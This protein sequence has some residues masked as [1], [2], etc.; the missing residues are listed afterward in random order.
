[1]LPP[2]LLVTRRLSH[3]VEARAS[4]DYDAR[5]NAD[6]ANWAMDGPEITR[7]ASEVGA[8]GILCAPG[9]RVDSACINALPP[10]V[11][12]IATLSVGFDHID[13]AAARARGIV[14]TNTPGVLS[15]AVA[16]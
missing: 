1:M 16:E 8:A 9:D 13:L 2:V 11:K 7:R 15:F 12:I 14:V 6:N 5:L 3:A 10:S 4:R